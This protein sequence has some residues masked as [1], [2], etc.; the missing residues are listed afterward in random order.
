MCGNGVLIT[1]TLIITPRVAIPKIPDG[2]CIVVFAA[3][4]G[5]TP[6]RTTSGALAVTGTTQVAGATSTAFVFPQD[7]SRILLSG[8][9]F[10]KPFSVSD[11]LDL[12]LAVYQRFRRRSQSTFSRL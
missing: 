4:L 1:I 9:A 10:S 2:L 8:R 11:V 5:T 12:G 3:V 7:K 6:N